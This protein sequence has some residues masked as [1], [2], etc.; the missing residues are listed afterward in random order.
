MLDIAGFKKIA[1]TEKAVQLLNSFNAKVDE[2][3][4]KY[5]D[6]HKVIFDHIGLLNSK[7]NCKV[8]CVEHV[9]IIA[10]GIN[11]KFKK[12]ESE[13]Q[14]NLKSAINFINE[15]VESFENNVIRVG[16]DIGPVS[17]VNT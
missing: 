4:S 16:M 10:A 9:Y 2:I 15:L 7:I 13:T 1:E 6:L 11:S 12:N 3:L 8:D 17:A 14:S 5:E